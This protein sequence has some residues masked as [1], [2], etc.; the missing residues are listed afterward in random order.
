MLQIFLRE[1]SSSIFEFEV[2]LLRDESGGGERQVPTGTTKTATTEPE[3]CTFSWATRSV[4][5]S[6]SG[7]MGYSP[8]EVWKSCHG[9][10]TSGRVRKVF[11]VRESFSELTCW[12]ASLENSKCRANKVVYFQ[13]FGEVCRSSGWWNCWHQ[14]HLNN[15]GWFSWIELKHKRLCSYVH[16]FRC[17]FQLCLCSPR[18]SAVL[19]TQKC[20]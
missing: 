14:K 8:G 11:S 7:S 18:L 16:K 13:K 9:T 19:S 5:S 6:A 20:D 15:I 12:K 17:R 1:I 10:R 4:G 3:V 2:F